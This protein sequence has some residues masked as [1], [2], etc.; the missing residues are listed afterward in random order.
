MVEAL[1]DRRHYKDNPMFQTVRHPSG[2]DYIAPGA[3]GTVSPDI[4][5]PVQPAPVLG[6]HT[7]EVLATVLGMSSGEIGRLHDAKLV[8]G[9]DGR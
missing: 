6:Q 8:A 5:G 2:R 4:R 7:D 1:D 3:M 9:I